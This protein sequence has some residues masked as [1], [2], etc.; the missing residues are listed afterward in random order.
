MRNISAAKIQ[1]RSK[2]NYTSHQ[3]ACQAIVQP[4]IS[5]FFLYSITNKTIL[6]TAELCIPSTIQYLLIYCIT[7]EQVHSNFWC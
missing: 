4:K 7:T 2:D 1:A 6:Q 5:C 3:C